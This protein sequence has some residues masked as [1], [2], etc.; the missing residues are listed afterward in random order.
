MVT[1]EPPC[2]SSAMGTIRGRSGR[3]RNAGSPTCWQ[4]PSPRTRR[5]CCGAGG[6]QRSY[7][8]N[9][10]LPAPAPEAPEAPGEAPGVQGSQAPL[11]ARTRRIAR[12]ALLKSAPYSSCCRRKGAQGSSSRVGTTRTVPEPLRNVGESQDA[13][14]SRG[15]PALLLEHGSGRTDVPKA[16]TRKGKSCSVW[17]ELSPERRRVLQHHLHLRSSGWIQDPCGKWVKDGNAEFDS[18]EEEPPELPPT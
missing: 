5:C 16:P 12:S 7:G 4:I 2:P 6:L 14:E 1:A 18:D 11:L 8:R 17:D 3:C 10:S 15:S 9:R 13:G